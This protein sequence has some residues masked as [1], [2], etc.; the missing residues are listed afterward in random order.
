MIFY[1]VVG[2]NRD[3]PKDDLCCILLYQ[4]L[5]SFPCLLVLNL[6]GTIMDDETFNT[7]ASTCTNLRS[8]SC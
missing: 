4:F 3:M 7:V 6:E 5:L 1:Q 2:N 8:V